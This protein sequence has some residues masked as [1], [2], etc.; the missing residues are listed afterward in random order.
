MSEQRETGGGD[1]GRSWVG[2]VAD[3]TRQAAHRRDHQHAGT[4]ECHPH[5]VEVVHLGQQGV[6]VCHDCAADSGF[7]PLRAAERL[8]EEHRRQTREGSVPLPRAG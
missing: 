4:L 5:A 2:G 1:A 6:T 3:C 8:A 7:L